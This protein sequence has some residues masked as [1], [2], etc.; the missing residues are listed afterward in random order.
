MGNPR[1]ALVFLAYKRARE[2]LGATG[3]VR[4]D[5]CVNVYDVEE[6]AQREA[7]LLASKIGEAEF[8][9]TIVGEL[10]AKDSITIALDEWQ[11]QAFTQAS[12]QKAYVKKTLNW[13]A[14]LGAAADVVR[15]MVKDTLSRDKLIASY[16]TAY[17]SAPRYLAQCRRKTKSKHQTLPLE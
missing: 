5:T 9:Q 4:R 16:A 12:L 17:E 7:L 11:P 13:T 3:K 2:K 6:M 1:R 8:K 14:V 10:T 15:R